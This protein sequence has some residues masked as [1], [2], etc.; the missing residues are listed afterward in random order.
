MAK[1]NGHA[2]WVVPTIIAAVLAGITIADRLGSPTAAKVTAC[3]V[4]SS[5]HETR[6]RSVENDTTTLKTQLVGFKATLDEIRADVKEIKQGHG[7]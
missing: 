5:D 3:E 6:L 2:R 1:I 4:K 7:R